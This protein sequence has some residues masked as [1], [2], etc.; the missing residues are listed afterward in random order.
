MILP[1]ED[2]KIST[3]LRLPSS[4]IAAEKDK[5]IS[6]LAINLIDQAEI[7]TRNKHLPVFFYFLT[8]QNRRN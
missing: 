4:V 6:I 5:T 3:K 2:L 1:D 8:S 7:L